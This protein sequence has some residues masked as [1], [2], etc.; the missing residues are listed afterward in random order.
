MTPEERWA[1][2]ILVGLWVF[3]GTVGFYLCL[4]G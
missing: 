2:A 4:T 1:L 3:L